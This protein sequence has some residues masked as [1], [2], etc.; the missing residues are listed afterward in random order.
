[1]WLSDLQIVLPDRT[2]ERGA[3]RIEGACIAEI[4]EGPAP[5][6]AGERIVQGQ[7]LTAIPGIIDMHGDMLETEVEPRP[8]ASFP[9]DLAVLELDK[10]LAASGITTAYAGISFWETVRREKQRSAE[11]AR[12]MVAAIHA[13]RDS[14]LIDLYVHA[15]YEVTTPSVMPVLIDLLEQ[16]QI[17]LLSLMDHTPGQGQYRNLEQYVDFIAKWRNA[18]PADVEAETHERLRASQNRAMVWERVAEIVALA[19]AQGLPVASHDDDTTDKIDLMSG[20]GVMISEFPVT[21]H[22][23]EEARRRGIAVAMGAPNVLRG[24]SHANNLSAIEAIQAGAVD[25]LAADYSPAALLQAVF[26][27][28]E[29][30]VLPLHA[31]VKLIGENP[32]SALGLCDR[33]RIEVGLSADIVLIEQ[34]ARPRVR[35]TIRRGVPIYWDAAM[36]QRDHAVTAGRDTSNAPAI[37]R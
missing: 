4:A 9:M 25:I 17:H 5:T 3:L 26:V 37:S 30:G 19:L 13:L 8:G 20:L 22:A 33:G 12:Q 2:L 23:A 1:M 21:L 6:A 10:R 34:A 18:N 27:L 35:G 29:K 14:L 16:R 15:R 24:V 32:A 28:V 11:R 7:G 36:A 31:A